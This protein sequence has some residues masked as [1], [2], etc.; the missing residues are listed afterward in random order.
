MPPPSPGMAAGKRCVFRVTDSVRRR[1]DA[2]G[3]CASLWLGPAAKPCRAARIPSRP[4]AHTIRSDFLTLQVGVSLHE[5]QMA[6]RGTQAAAA[7]LLSSSSSARRA[8]HAKATNPLERVGS[9]ISKDIDR[10]KKL[11]DALDVHG[12]GFL[13]PRSVVRML[14]QLVRAPVTKAGKEIQIPTNRSHTNIM[15]SIA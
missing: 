14:N 15:F 5:F 10:A 2:P 4:N 12:R 6:V 11:F 13:T 9:R 7:S 1:G 3:T 8:P